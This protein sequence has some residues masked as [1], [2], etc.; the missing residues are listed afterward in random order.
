MQDETEAICL[1]SSQAALEERPSVG[2]HVSEVS[3]DGFPHKG[4]FTTG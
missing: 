2:R 1:K 3:R 4:D